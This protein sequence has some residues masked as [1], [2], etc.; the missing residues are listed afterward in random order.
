MNTKTLLTL[1]TVGAMA[2]PMYA[3]LTHVPN[4]ALATLTTA[5][6]VVDGSTQ[7]LS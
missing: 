4:Q 6:V 3:A 5:S 1:A 2:A 7:K